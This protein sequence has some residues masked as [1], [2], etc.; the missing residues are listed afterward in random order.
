MIDHVSFSVS[1]IERSKSF[2]LACLT[3]LGLRVLHDTINDSTAGAFAFV[4]FGLDHPIFCINTGKALSP[5]LHV[6]FRAGTREDVDAFY[7]AALG[8]GGADNGPPGLRPQYHTDYYGAYVRD[9]DGHNIEAVCHVP[10]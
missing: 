10:G 2:Y 3:T 4:C 1:D 5:A 6:A 7:A 9:P 8:A